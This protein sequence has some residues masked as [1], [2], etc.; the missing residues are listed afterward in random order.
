MKNSLKRKIPPGQHVKKY[1]DYFKQEIWRNISV[2]EP[3][4]LWVEPELV[5]NILTRDFGHYTDRRL[6][7]SPKPDPLNDHLII[8]GNE[9]EKNANPSYYHLHIWEDENVSN[10][11]R[12]QWQPCKENGSAG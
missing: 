10:V 1:Y 2:F 11:G 6:V 12:L 4:L 9:L 7:I 5:K 3:V 8:G